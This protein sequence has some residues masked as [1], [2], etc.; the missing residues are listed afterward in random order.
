[1]ARTWP[2]KGARSDGAEH[3]DGDARPTRRLPLAQLLQLSVYWF[4][5]NATWGG[6]EI[7]QQERISELVDPTEA[8]R[9][10]AV[11]ETLAAVVAI[12]VQPTFGTISDYTIS[13]WGR[14]KPY[15]A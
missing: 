1:M 3:G 2:R 10:L 14:R 6:F 7:F 5:I 11:M 8:G 13:R 15:I 4:G 12:A 9:W